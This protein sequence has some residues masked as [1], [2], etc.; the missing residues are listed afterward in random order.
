MRANGRIKGALG[1]I[2]AAHSESLRGSDHIHPSELCRA[3]PA[4]HGKDLGAL[5]AMRRRRSHVDGLG[6]RPGPRRR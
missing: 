5:P 2:W 3:P 4:E 6:G 1:R